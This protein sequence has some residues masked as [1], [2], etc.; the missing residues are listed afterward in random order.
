MCHVAG[1]Q[2][3]AK[4][5]LPCD[6]SL[7]GSRGC[8]S[9]LRIVCDAA[10]DDDRSFYDCLHNRRSVCKFPPQAE[11][12]VRPFGVSQS[13]AAHGAHSTA[14]NAH[15]VARAYVHDEAFNVC[16]LYRQSDKSL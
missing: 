5:C 12:L 1:L 14:A 2:S 11:E 16:G 15:L 9:L 6:E 8:T 10:D 7:P 3:H 13:N 4:G